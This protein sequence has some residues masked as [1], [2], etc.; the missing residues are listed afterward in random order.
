MPRSGSR[1]TRSCVCT[2][3]MSAAS[4]S[5][6]RSALAQVAIIPRFEPGGHERDLGAWAICTP[7]RARAACTSTPHLYENDRPGDGEIQA[8]RDLQRRR[9]ADLDTHDWAFFLAGSRSRWREPAGAAQI[10]AHAGELRSNRELA[11]PRRDGHVDRALPD[12]AALPRAAARCRWRRT[13]ASGVGLAIGTDIGAGD[14]WADPAG[15]ESTLQVHMSEP[16]ADA[17]TLGVPRSCCSSACSLECRALD[18]EALDRQPGRWQGGHSPRWMPG[19]ARPRRSARRAAE[20]GAELELCSPCRWACA[21][22]PSLR[23]LRAR[24]WF[25][26]PVRTTAPRFPALA[27]ALSCWSREADSSGVA[28]WGSPRAEKSERSVRPAGPQPVPRL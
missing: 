4:P 9:S 14:E 23:L 13:V 7:M 11:S 16:G 2:A 10:L 18:Q 19:P 21:R 27:P 28:G 3:G 17:E 20:R 26:A 24:R 5:D 15:A 1:A 25:V 22:T 12:V 6:P 8:V